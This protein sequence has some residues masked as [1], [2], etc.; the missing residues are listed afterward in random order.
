VIINCCKA[1]VPAQGVDQQHQ[2]EYTGLSQNNRRAGRGIQEIAQVDTDLGRDTTN[3]YGID[4]H[5][6]KVISQ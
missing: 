2:H 3:D 5:S 4:E 1:A 6:A